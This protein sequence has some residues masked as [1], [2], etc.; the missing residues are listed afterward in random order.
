MRALLA[1]LPFCPSPAGI[2]LPRNLRFSPRRMTFVLR[3]QK[4]GKKHSPAKPPLRGA[5]RCSKP[6][7]EPQALLCTS[8]R[9]R[10]AKSDVGLSFARAPGFCAS[11]PFGRGGPRTAQ[12]PTAKP[13]SRVHRGIPLAPFSPAEERKARSPRAKL[14]SGTDARRLP[15][16][17]GVARVRRG[18]WGLSRAGNP[19]R[20]LVRG[21]R[22]AHFDD[23]LAD[24]KTEG[25]GKVTRQPGPK[26]KGS[27][28]ANPGTGL[29][30]KT[31][32]P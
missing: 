13:A 11:R 18:P 27:P 26:S 19:T 25:F 16:P 32:S 12:Q 23:F 22:G 28:K 31:K 8:F 7:A 29:R 21:G 15:E 4:V 10:G 30:V 17:I 2:C 20:S 6:G 14:A 24:Q 1:H 5:L 3:R 9:P